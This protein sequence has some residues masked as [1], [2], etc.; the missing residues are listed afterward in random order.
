MHRP[1]FRAEKLLME[2]GVCGGD[3][4]RFLWL[5][6]DPHLSHACRASHAGASR[7]S[8]VL[9][10]AV[11]ALKVLT[12]TASSRPKIQRDGALPY[13]AEAQPRG[14]STLL[15]QGALHDRTQKLYDKP[16][17]ISSHWDF[18]SH[19]PQVTLT[20]VQKAPLQSLGLTPLSP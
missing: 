12:L 19:L 8:M 15:W 1:F 14:E 5:L 3:V 10:S 20:R 18:L 11:C 16:L 9:W 2:V 13:S 17:C 6:V 7:V 4:W